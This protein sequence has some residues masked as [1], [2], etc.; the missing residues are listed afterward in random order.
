MRWQGILGLAFG[1]IAGPVSTLIMQTTAYN[2]VHWACGHKS[3]GPV[4]IVPVMFLL[5]A[6]AALWISWR[7]WSSVGRTGHAEG[8]T[9]ADRTRF[10]ALLGVSLSAYSI[11]IMLW[12]WVPMFVFDP[13][14]R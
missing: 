11:V 13:C 2:G 10:V 1:L 12:M 9:V 3:P 4:H 6:A 7:D 8:P 14:Q 5:V